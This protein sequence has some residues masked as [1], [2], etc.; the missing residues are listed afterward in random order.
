MP[1]GPPDCALGHTG[2]CQI[3]FSFGMASSYRASYAV[4]YTLT[5]YRVQR[6]TA[7]RSIPVVRRVHLTLDHGRRGRRRCRSP[8]PV[9]RYDIKIR[10]ELRHGQGCVH[11]IYVNP[12]AEGGRSGRK[13]YAG[14][15][16]WVVGPTHTHSTLALANI[17]LPFL[18]PPV[19]SFPLLSTFQLLYRTGP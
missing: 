16:G 18:S 9:D 4:Q 11:P 6:N 14:R 1:C 2:I 3:M 5:A 17:Y 7:R 10:S 12:S 8:G 13:A 15:Y 19:T